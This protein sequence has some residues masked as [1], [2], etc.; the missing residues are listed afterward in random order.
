MSA[1]KRVE[2]RLTLNKGLHA[3]AHARAWVSARTPGLTRDTTDDA[4][5]IVS[6]LVTNA[7]RHGDGDIVV[8]L[9]VR[10]DRMRIEVRDDS[11]ELPVIPTEHPPTDRPAGRGLL[12][13]AATASDWGVERVRGDLGKT[14]WAELPVNSP[15]K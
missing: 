15:R 1:E 14:V 3:P 11:P 2:N 7:V 9:D 6:E 13:V 10:A 12:I 5:L 8:S 4:L